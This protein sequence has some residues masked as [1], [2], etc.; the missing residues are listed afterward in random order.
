MEE[1]PDPRSVLEAYEAKERAE[2]FDI[3]FGESPSPKV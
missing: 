1:S 2:R 3:L